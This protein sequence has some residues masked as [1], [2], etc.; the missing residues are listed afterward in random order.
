LSRTTRVLGFSVPKEL[1]DDYE[2]LAQA[3]H[4]TKSQ[5]FR[6][7]VRTY[8][9]SKEIAEFSELRQ[10]GARKAAEAGIKTEDDIL[11]L[12]HEERGV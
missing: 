1:A 2:R 10:Y 7:M 5:L 12:I 4:K 9:E 11:R 8:Q 3:E 6:E